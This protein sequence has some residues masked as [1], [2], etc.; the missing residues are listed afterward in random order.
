MLYEVITMK[1]RFVAVFVIAVL[2]SQNI[3]AQKWLQNLPKEKSKTEYTLFD[4]RDAFNNYWDDYNVKGGY[5][6]VDGVKHKA[7]GWKQFYRWS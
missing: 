4:Y 1:L 2:V 7:R 5:Y 6:Y 3:S